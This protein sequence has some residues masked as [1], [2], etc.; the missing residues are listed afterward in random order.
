MTHDEEVR[1]RKVEDAIIS[2]DNI[3]KIVIVDIKERVKQLEANDE[4]FSKVIYQTCDLKSKEIETKIKESEEK[5]YPAIRYGRS[6]VMVLLAGMFSLFVGAVVYFN[7]QIGS[8]HEKINK[9]HKE[10]ARNESA[11][12][13]DIKSILSE[14]KYIRT[15]LDIKQSE[16]H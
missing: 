6:S 5:I 11:N 8:I 7:G 9:S 3:A 4:E 16:K 1:L 12:S 10:T 14:L 15:R 13:A 2:F